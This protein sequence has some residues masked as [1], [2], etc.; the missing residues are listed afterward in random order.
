MNSVIINNMKWVDSLKQR[1]RELKRDT[2]ALW[3]AYRDP[4]TPWYAKGFSALVVAYALSPIDLIPDFIPV[5]GYLDDLI[6]IPAGIALALKMIPADV[7]AEARIKA[8]VQIKDGKP[9]NWVVGG[10][11]IALWLVVLFFA[12]RTIYRAVA[13]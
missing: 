7:M 9:V 3:F 1:A 2:M 6:L 4:R 13:K 8:E 11:I 12:G 5:L 10:I